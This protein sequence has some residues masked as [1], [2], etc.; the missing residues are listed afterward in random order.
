MGR[1]VDRIQEYIAMATTKT[2]PKAVLESIASQIGSRLDPPAGEEGHALALDAPVPSNPEI[3]ET[4]EVWKLIP[5]SVDEIKKGN[6]DITKLARPAG[7]WHHQLRQHKTA[8]GFARS[9]PLGADPDSWSVRDIYTSDL[10]AKI[11]DAI[12]WVDR[13]I[14][15]DV[16]EVR[17]LSMPIQQVEAFWFVAKSPEAEKWNNQLFIIHSREA[18]DELGQQIDAKSFLSSLPE[19]ARGMG[20][21]TTPRK[22]VF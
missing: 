17:L 18:I 8:F 9:K 10:A 19:N 2:L 13:H 5:D 14:P 15:D 21:R 12:K 6:L 7:L 3:G 11:D 22:E 20:I 16:V 1:N 4:F